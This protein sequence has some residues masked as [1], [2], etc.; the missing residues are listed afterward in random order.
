MKYLLLIKN[1]FKITSVKLYLFAN[2]VLVFIFGFLYYI[3]DYFISNNTEFAKKINLVPKTY[4]GSYSSDNDFLYY[5]WWSLVTQTT[6]GYAGLL[7]EKTGENIPFSKMEYRS[8][9]GLN[10]LQLFSV[11]FV[12]ILLVVQ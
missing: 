11:I 7:N 12:N 8:F 9:K 6:V 3:N 10:I 4:D 2:L 5:L 1:K